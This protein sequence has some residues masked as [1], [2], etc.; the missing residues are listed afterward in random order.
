MGGSSSASVI[1]KNG[2]DGINNVVLQDF[3]VDGREDVRTNCIFIGGD[4]AD[5]NTSIRLE[6]LKVQNC[7]EH[8]IHIKGTNQLVI[9]EIILNESADWLFNI[10]FTVRA[11]YSYGFLDE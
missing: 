3:R 4:D 6:G 11:F 1:T 5:R 9:D 2:S 7:G 8:G 10:P